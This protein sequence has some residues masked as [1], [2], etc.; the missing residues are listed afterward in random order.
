MQRRL[1]FQVG[2]LMAFF[3]GFRADKSRIE[4]VFVF[5]RQLEGL[6]VNQVLAQPKGGYNHYYQG[7]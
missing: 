6:L 4:S 1:P 2:S 7:D 5:A 3:A